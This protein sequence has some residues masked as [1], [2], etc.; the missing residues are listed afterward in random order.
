MTEARD[1]ELR[2]GVHPPAGGHYTRPGPAGP[3]HV[4][5]GTVNSP[6]AAS[7]TWATGLA[8]TRSLPS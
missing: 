5:A 2:P 3:V 4:N 8:A 7:R 6:Y 1:R